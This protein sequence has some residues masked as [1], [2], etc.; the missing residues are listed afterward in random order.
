MYTDEWRQLNGVWLHF[1]DWQ[2]GH[3][4][5]AEAKAETIRPSVS[6]DPWKLTLAAAR[7]PP[8]AR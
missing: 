7:E 8:R 6:P 5:S 4:S 3:D 1:Q 2:D